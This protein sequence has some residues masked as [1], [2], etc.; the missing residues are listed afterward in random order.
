MAKTFDSAY[1]TQDKGFQRPRI[2][3]IDRDV[4]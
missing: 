1:I 4:T 3:F 2:S